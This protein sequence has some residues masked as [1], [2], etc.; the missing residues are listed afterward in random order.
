MQLPYEQKL[1]KIFNYICALLCCVNAYLL[2][3][4]SIK[5]YLRQEIQTATLAS[6]N[7]INR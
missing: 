1:G 6:A 7:A 5:K 4:H 3:N 2:L